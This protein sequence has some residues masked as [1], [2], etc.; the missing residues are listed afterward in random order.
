[1]G[2]YLAGSRAPD[3][4]DQTGGLIWRMPSIKDVIRPVT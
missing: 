2:M 4:L 3:F 1:M